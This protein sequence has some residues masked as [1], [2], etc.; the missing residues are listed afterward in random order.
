MSGA[1]FGSSARAVVVPCADSAADKSGV[2]GC[3]TTPGADFRC[4]LAASFSAAAS[5]ASCWQAPPE[6]AS[7]CRRGWGARRIKQV[8]NGRHKLCRRKGLGQQNTIREA[9]GWPILAM[10]PGR[11]DDGERWVDLSGAPGHLP[12]VDRPEQI[13]V[14]HDSPIYGLI[15]LKKR[16]GFSPDPVITDLKPPSDRASST[17]P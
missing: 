1:G 14:G 5:A 6:P 4:A 9:P 10:R 11:I 16:N 3:S 13:D 15:R 2:A 7:R 8:G 12:A 17:I